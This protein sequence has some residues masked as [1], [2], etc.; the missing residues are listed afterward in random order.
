MFNRILVAVD[1]SEDSRHVFET[2]LSLAKAADTRLLLLHILPPQGINGKSVHLNADST[3]GSQAQFCPQD[4]QSDEAK[5]WQILR[6]L[7]VRAADMGITADLALLRGEPS[8]II[9]QEACRWGA[10]LIVVGQQ[11]LNEPIADRIKNYATYHALC[12]VLIVQH[13]ST[14]IAKAN[15]LQKV[16][17]HIF[18]SFQKSEILPLK[19]AL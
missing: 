18:D 12:L 1:N 6:S 7:L 9:C 15:Q 17:N 3:V 8:Q 16:K 2:A 11:E 14:A 10:D 13:P 19:S 4:W 5:G